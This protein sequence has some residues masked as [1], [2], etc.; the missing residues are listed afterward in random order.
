MKVY[1]NGQK[2]ITCHSCEPTFDT[3]MAWVSLQPH[4]RRIYGC[5]FLPHHDYGRGGRGW[6]DL[7]QDCLSLIL[8][9]PESVRSD[10]KNFFAGIRADGTNATIIGSQ[11][12]RIYC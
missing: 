5:S 2:I 7:W 1:W 8:I 12:G 10:L 4:L 6:R 9:D 3:W 11:S